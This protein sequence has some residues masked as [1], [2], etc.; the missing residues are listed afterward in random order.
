MAVVPGRAILGSVPGVSDGVA[1]SSRALS[2]GSNTV[3]LVGVVL[4]DTVEV[5]AG[6]V[7][8]KRVLDVDD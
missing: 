2:D 5:N 4:A 7:V 8:L 6:A 1:R 3:S